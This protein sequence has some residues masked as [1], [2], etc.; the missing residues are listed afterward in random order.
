MKYIK[1]W[2]AGGFPLTPTDLRE[3]AHDYAEALGK[4]VSSGDALL[5]NWLYYFLDRHDETLTIKKP[6]EMSMYRATAATE[7]CIDAF[8]EKYHSMLEELG[9]TSGDQV[10]NID[11]TGLQN[12]VKSTRVIGE[13]GTNHPFVS[14]GEKGET[15]T[16]LCFVSASGLKTR[17]MVIFKGKN[18]MRKWK[19][20][21]PDD[22]ILRCS[23]RGWITKELFAEYSN[24]LIQFLNDHNM[25]DKKHLL[26][27]DQHVTHEK[28]YPFL[29]NMA[30]HDVEVLSLPSHT[31]HFLQPL[32]Q[33]PFTEL[34]RKWQDALRVWN[35]EH[36]GK[37]LSKQQ[38]FLVFPKVWRRSMT[39]PIIQAGWRKCG[40]WPLN[41]L[42]VNPDWFEPS[43]LCKTMIVGVC[44]C[45]SSVMFYCS[46]VCLIK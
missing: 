9:I 24:V 1:S 12:Y 10:W 45:S 44:Y 15:H 30:V 21:L 17:P 4:E 23:E 34:K 39:I 11:E 43:K 28:N 37:P 29:I 42:R 33:C 2:S 8:F 40:L 46:L 26:L 22:V 6:K 41:K 20:F 19:E 5:R 27:L 7:E 35:R 32:D 16:V 14:A 3:I 36:C 13:K 18:M 25:L 38:F 31:T